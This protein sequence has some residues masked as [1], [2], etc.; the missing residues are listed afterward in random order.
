MIKTKINK[1]LL[2]AYEF[3]L[4]VFVVLNHKFCLLE[5]KQFLIL[6]RKTKRNHK[7]NETKKNEG[8]RNGT[9]KIEKRNEM[10]RI[11]T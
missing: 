1:Q 10:K 11:K 3:V 4:V 2:T 5:I 7:R 9:T 8:P 6:L